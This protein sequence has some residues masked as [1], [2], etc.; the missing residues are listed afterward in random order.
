MYSKLPTKIKSRRIF[1][2][3]KKKKIKRGSGL[4]K[5]FKCFY[6]QIQKTGV[7]RPIKMGI[8]LNFFHL[9]IEAI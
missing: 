8:L 1:F 2:F 3:K 4:P 6:D 5:T 7:S 9:M